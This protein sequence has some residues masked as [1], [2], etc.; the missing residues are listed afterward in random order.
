MFH[1]IFHFCTDLWKLNFGFK[2][3]R[4]EV[5]KQNWVSLFS[6]AKSALNLPCLRRS[7]C[8]LGCPCF[9]TR[10]VPVLHIC[11]NWIDVSNSTSLSKLQKHENI[12]ILLFNFMNIGGAHNG[13]LPIKTLNTMQNRVWWFSNQVQG[14][15]CSYVKPRQFVCWISTAQITYIFSQKMR[16]EPDN[17]NPG[18]P[19]GRTWKSNLFHL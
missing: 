12:K 1:L 11:A 16:N 7:N 2:G 15:S 17:G 4:I 9:T 3:N 13:F 8:V 10:V 6:V 14:W 19:N 5:C 18:H